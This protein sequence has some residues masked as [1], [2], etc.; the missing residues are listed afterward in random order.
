VLADAMTAAIEASDDA[1]A[2]EA[3]ARGTYASVTA[4]KDPGAALASVEIVEAMARRLRAPSFARAL[5]ENNIGTAE[6]ARGRRAEAATRFQRALAESRQIEGPDAVELLNVRSNAAMVV[7]DSARRDTSLAEAEAAFDRWLGPEHPET[8]RLRMRRGKLVTDL[9]AAR[10]LLSS[11]CARYDRYHLAAAASL[12]TDCWAE[13]GYVLE[14]LGDRAGA[15]AALERVTR[16]PRDSGYVSPEPAGYLLLFRGD[17]HAAS[18]HFERAIDALPRAHDISWWRKL[19]RGQLELGLGR[20]RLEAGDG[21]GAC[22][23]LAQAVD[24]LG[25]IAEQ[26]PA[27]V[28]NRR[29]ARAHATHARALVA[30]GAPAERIAEAARKALVLLQD[31]R[32]RTDEISALLR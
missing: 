5:L 20:A 17:G 1:L 31:E 3:W 29:L 8:L 26:H 18:A 23:A 30:T 27:A 22:S 2:V 12:T 21:A 13:L 15:V 28:V 7:D 4:G 32:A 14:E 25:D 9:A 11:A 6:L 10:D 24:D 16:L 19:E